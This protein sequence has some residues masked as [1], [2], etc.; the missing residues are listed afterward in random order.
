MGVG[1]TV[2]L[3]KLAEIEMRCQ[4]SQTMT[5]H[6]DTILEFVRLAR[7][8]LEEQWRP[9]ETIEF[10]SDWDLSKPFLVFSP[11]IGIK[12]G[13]GMGVNKDKI[14]ISVAGYHGC[15]LASWG[16]THW[17]PL[18]PPPKDTP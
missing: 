3:E 2:T 12:V 13:S 9:I 5:F 15:A 6:A 18:S 16:V 17:K 11:N 8:G 1:V 7:I 10:K 4:P 14:F